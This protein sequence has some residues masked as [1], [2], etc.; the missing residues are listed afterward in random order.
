MN[1]FKKTFQFTYNL[2]LRKRR[3][4]KMSALLIP[5]VP[6]HGVMLDLGCGNGDLAAEIQK[7][8][9][10]LEILGIDVQEH[11]ESKIPMKVYD[12]NVIP[13]NDEH[14]DHIMII[15]ALH[16][17]DDYIPVLKEAIR[18]TRKQI[19][20]YDHQYSNYKEWL[21]LVITDWPGN[22]PFGVY[23]PFNFK[24][25]SEWKNLFEQLGLVEVS[26]RDSFSYYG[27]LSFFFGKN[28]HFI[29]VLEKRQKI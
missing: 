18:V 1:I 5:S 11:K 29:S 8:A 7:S 24:K 4:E 25:R 28:T 9:P 13:Y 12:G 26:Y 22:V 2:L 27:I 3:L 16:H 21:G 23:T 10:D 17:T 6:K 14:F 19:I 20:I 15:T